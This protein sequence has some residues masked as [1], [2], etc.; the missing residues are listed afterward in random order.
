[1]HGVISNRDYLPLLGGNQEQQQNNLQWLEFSWKTSTN[2]SK[3]G[4]SCSVLGVLLDSLWLLGEA[5]SVQ[6]GD[7]FKFC[8]YIY[9]HTLVCNFRWIAN[10]II[11]MIFSNFLLLPCWFPP[12]SLVKARLSHFFCFLPLCCPSLPRMVSVSFSDCRLYVHIWR[13]GLLHF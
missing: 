5:L 7:F 9:M 11:F 6:M 3:R 1:M 4:F 8:V 2:N 13:F 12:L 10:D